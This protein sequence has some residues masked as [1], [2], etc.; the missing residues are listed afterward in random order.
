[1]FTFRTVGINRKAFQTLIMR[2]GV[3]NRNWAFEEDDLQQMLF[4]TKNN[5]KKN[6]RDYI[7]TDMRRVKDYPPNH[8]LVKFCDIVTNFVRDFLCEVYKSS[9]CEA[10]S[11]RLQRHM[12]NDT[13]LQAFLGDLA[14]ELGLSQSNELAKF[15]DIV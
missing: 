9:S 12:D 10:S 14:G 8:D 2:K 6:F 15:D 3:V 11:L 4:S 13:E 5:F 7:P 1:M